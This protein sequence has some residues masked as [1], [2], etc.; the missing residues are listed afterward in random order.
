L[1]TDIYDGHAPLLRERGY[2]PIPIGPGTKKPQRY[3]PSTKAYEGY[4]GW[5][6]RPTSLTTPQPGAGIGVRCGNGIV[7]IDYDDEDA[8]LRVSEALGDSPVSK[9]GKTAWTSF[10][11]ASREVLSEDFVNEDSRY[12][13]L[14]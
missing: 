3:I 1:H 14:A 13:F 4:S 2:F 5:Q 10:F 7:A 11:R 6:E 12:R 8:A 9:A